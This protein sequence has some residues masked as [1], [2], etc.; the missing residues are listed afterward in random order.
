MKCQNVQIKR[1]RICLG[2][3]NRQV[4]LKTRAID[5]PDTPTDYDYD[6]EFTTLATVWAAIQTM[7]GKDLFDGVNMIGTATHI[8]YIKYRSDVTAETM[9]EY[10]SK[11]YRI[12]RTEDLDQNNEFM[13]LYCALR[14]DK[15]IN[16]NLQ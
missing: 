13:A 10:Q 5:T 15:T 4:T 8:F 9:I 6:Q 3:L 12:L 14:G 1:R 16:V 2:D 11:N 7:S